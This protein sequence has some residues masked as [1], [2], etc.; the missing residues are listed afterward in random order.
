MRQ[1]GE[2]LRG[3]TSD[4]DEMILKEIMLIAGKAQDGYKGDEFPKKDEINKQ[5]RLS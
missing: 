3:E 1:R 2:R 4:R 5:Q